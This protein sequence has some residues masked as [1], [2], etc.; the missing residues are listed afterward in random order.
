V[1]AELPEG[2]YFTGS[3]QVTVSAGGT[4]PF[5]LVKARARLSG[6]VRDDSGIGLAGVVLHLRSGEDVRTATT[7]SRG[8]YRFAVAEGEY[9]LEL[10]RESVPA[11]YDAA[12]T[13]ITRIRL[14]QDAP[15]QSDMVFPANRSIAGKVH[16]VL[17]GAATGAVTIVELGRYAVL[18]G[19]GHYVFRQ[20]APGTYTVEATIG[21]QKMRRTIEV[22]AGPAAIRDVDFP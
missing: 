11:G 2:T 18:D 13:T 21:D 15:A 1:Q 7:D 14:E 3:S 8:H 20:L 5:G 22:P 19:E 16:A 4:V 17:G 12:A 6:F 9:E 10:A